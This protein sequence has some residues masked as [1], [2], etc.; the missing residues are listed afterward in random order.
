L[1]WHLQFDRL[2]ADQEDA[3]TDALTAL[4]NTRFMFMHLTRELAR[5]NRLKSEVSLLVMAS[6]HDGDSYETLLATAD[7]RMYRDKTRRKRHASGLSA[8]PEDQPRAAAPSSLSDIELQQSAMG[9]L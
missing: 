4:P 5:G 3:L 1:I 6:T 2:R 9:I 7:S 8:L